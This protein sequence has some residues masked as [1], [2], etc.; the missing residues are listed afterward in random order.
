MYLYKPEKGIPKS[1]AILFSGGVESVLMYYLYV[2]FA[3]EHG[4]ELNV[5]TIDRNG[6]NIKRVIQKYDNLKEKL[7]DDI[8]WFSLYQS[9]AENH[10][11]IKEIISELKP[12]YDVI[13]LGVNEY[14]EGILPNSEYQ[15]AKER[16]KKSN[17]VV[18]PFLDMKKHEV[19]QKYS[20]LGIT[21]Y[22]SYDESCS[23]SETPCGKC[24]NCRE[25]KYALELLNEN[26]STR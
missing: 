9:S 12:V 23:I 7:N 15:F 6:T 22:L 2:Q 26:T 21:D 17:V 18:A 1:I 4:C 25:I 10:L 20:E 5:V 19:I 24:F 13:A 16:I 11:S 3:K 14:Y 8:S